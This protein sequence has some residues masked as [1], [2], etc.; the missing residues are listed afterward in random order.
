[1]TAATPTVED[2]QP[3]V[4]AAER[5]ALRSARLRG[6]I[7]LALGLF[8]LQ[9][10]PSQ[11]TTPV[12]FSFWLTKQGGD[13]FT[14]STNVGLIWILTG[15]VTVIAGILQLVRGPSFQWRRA[16]VVVLPFW[17]AATFAQLLAGQPANLTNL[18]AGTLAYAAPISLG[19]F[20]GILSERSGMAN[21]AIEGKFL[22]G[23]MVASV[24]ASVVMLALGP[25]GNPTIGV[26]IGIG[27]AAVTGVLV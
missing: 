22:L 24:V 13:A 15:I 26:L 21:I 7:V 3:G 18:F 17:I 5:A 9:F 6:A 27:A 2:I 16:M 25:E 12:T 14:I 10:V 8:A 19:A 20:A 11:M 1:M 23:S 4:S